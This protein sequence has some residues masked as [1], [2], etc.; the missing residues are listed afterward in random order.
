MTYSATNS[1]VVQV[2]KSAPDIHLRFMG[3]SRVTGRMATAVASLGRPE[4]SCP[5]L[6]VSW[7]TAALAR[8]YPIIP[9][10]T[11]STVK[12]Y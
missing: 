6:L 1:S 10:P 9:A 8:P 7:C 5:R 2:E 12:E 4:L 3:V 11:T